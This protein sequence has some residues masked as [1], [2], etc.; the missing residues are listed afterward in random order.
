MWYIALHYRLV[1]LHGPCDKKKNFVQ[2]FQFFGGIF[3]NS[4]RFSV[5]AVSV[6]RR[7]QQ[8]ENKTS[9]SLSHMTAERP[10]RHASRRVIKQIGRQVG[11]RASSPWLPREVSLTLVRSAVNGK[12]ISPLQTAL[13]SSPDVRPRAGWHQ[14]SSTWAEQMWHDTGRE[15]SPGAVRNTRPR[16]P[17]GILF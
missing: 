15:W 9:S 5:C 4:L 3:P 7:Q 2:F 1:R 16:F 11:I 12:M 6:E 14:C 17:N 8:W 13:T 10:E